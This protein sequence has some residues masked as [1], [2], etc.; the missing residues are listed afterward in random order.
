MALCV[1]NACEIYLIKFSKCIKPL[2]SVLLE[3]KGRRKEGKREEKKGRREGKSQSATQQ[4]KHE[5]FQNQATTGQMSKDPVRA[6][7]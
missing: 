1:Y 7:R 2:L 6:T 3:R 4:R 5:I